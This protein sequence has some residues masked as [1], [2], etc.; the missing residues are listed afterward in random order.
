MK[1]NQAVYANGNRQSEKQEPDPEVAP[2][3]KRR[4]FSA[5]YKLRILAEA[6]ACTERAQSERFCGVKVSTHPTWT[7]GESSETVALL[8]GCAARNG[9]ANQTHSQQRSHDWR[10]RTSS[11]VLAWNGLNG[12]STSKK[13]WQSCLGRCPPRLRTARR[14]HDGGRR[15]GPDYRRD[16][17]LSGFECAQKQ[18]VSRRKRRRSSSG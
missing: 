15:T 6:D 5:E 11:C 18:L 9:G 7:S 14:H 13:S 8:R 1:D 16:D 4:G 12:S 10:G 17:S 2:K 3:A